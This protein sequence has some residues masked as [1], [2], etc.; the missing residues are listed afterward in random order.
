MRLTQTC[1]I[2]AVRIARRRCRKVRMHL[3]TLRQQSAPRDRQRRQGR[4]DLLRER[5]QL[6]QTNAVI[7]TKQNLVSYLC[8]T[9]NDIFINMDRPLILPV[10]ALVVFC[11]EIS[12][13]LAILDNT[14]SCFVACLEHAMPCHAIDVPL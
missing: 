4:R 2:G 3:T 6:C 13:P 1:G 5:T 10:L 9:C 11:F 14:P 8:V 7:V 12:S